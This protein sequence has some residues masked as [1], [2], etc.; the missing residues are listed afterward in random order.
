MES[1]VCPLA[2]GFVPDELI[3]SFKQG[4]DHHR[5]CLTQW[6]RLLTGRYDCPFDGLLPCSHYNEW[7][8]LK[9]TT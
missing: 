5:G 9:E 8:K 4:A 7:K 1:G 3:C 2:K 6:W